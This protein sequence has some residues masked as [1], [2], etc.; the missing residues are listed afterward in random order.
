MLTLALFLRKELQTNWNAQ[1]SYSTL[2]WPLIL[3][4]N[5]TNT[6]VKDPI[7]NIYKGGPLH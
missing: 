6:Y 2:K 1:N 3:T 7:S 5:F 4:T